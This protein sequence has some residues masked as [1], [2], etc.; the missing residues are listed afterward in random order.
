M[1]PSPLR[2]VVW[3]AVFGCVLALLWGFFRDANAAWSA[4]A[5]GAICVVPSGLFALRL[6]CASSKQE[7]YATAFLAGE[8]IKI[9]SSVALFAVVAMLY[10]SADWLALMVTYIA[11]LQVYVVGL[12][13][14][15]GP[16]DSDSD[17]VRNGG[18]QQA[19]K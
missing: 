19:S 10:R 2:I 9:L 7:G 11:V 3:Q 8:G 5:G 16:A 4:L 1:T 14:R 12:A 6:A 13:T 15:M 18:T 17:G